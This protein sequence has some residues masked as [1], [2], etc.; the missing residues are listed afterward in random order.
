MYIEERS[1]QQVNARISADYYFFLMKLAEKFDKT[2]A[3]MAADLLENAIIDAWYLAKMPT[4]A[5]PGEPGATLPAIYGD[6][7]MREEYRK[8]MYDQYEI[9]VNGYKE[10]LAAKEGQT[11]E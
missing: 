11:A 2:R 5:F 8:F 9:S 10:E 6:G 1:T 4:A 3:A 7:E